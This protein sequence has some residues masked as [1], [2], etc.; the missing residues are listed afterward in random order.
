MNHESRMTLPHVN[1]KL[2]TPN[3]SAGAVRNGGER[4]AE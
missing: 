4:W 3:F 1:T 2:I